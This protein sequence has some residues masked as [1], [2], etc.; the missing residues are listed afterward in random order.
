MKRLLQVL[1]VGAWACGGPAPAAPTT[2]RVDA[3][4][5]PPT[6]QRPSSLAP[7]AVADGELDA[8]FVTAAIESASRRI[9]S[10]FDVRL[11]GN[12]RLHGK[13]SVRFTVGAEKGA[14]RVHTARVAE[15]TTGDDMLGVCIIDVVQSLEVAEAPRG[16]DV[17][18]EYPFVFLN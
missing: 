13:V 15:N 12:P 1:L 17:T 5:P 3:T 18:F 6:A 7:T 4:H 14:G 8:A 9:R 10:C 16:G 11:R 2:P